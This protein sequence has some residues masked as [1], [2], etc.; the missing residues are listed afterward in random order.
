MLKIIVGFLIGTVM[1]SAL[2]MG[3]L[4]PLVTN[5]EDGDGTP[6][7]VVT[8]VSPA[9][10]TDTYTSGDIRQ[11]LQDVRGQITTEDT[12]RYFDKLMACY[13]LKDTT[14]TPEQITDESSVLAVLPDMQKIHNAAVTLPLIEAGN[15]IKDPEIARYYYE[16]LSGAGW[17]LQPPAAR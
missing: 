1:V 2:F 5:G 10:D 16:L 12:R 15:Q 11:M 14:L 13:D 9:E 6:P 3:P 4:R 7:P 8:P 17:N